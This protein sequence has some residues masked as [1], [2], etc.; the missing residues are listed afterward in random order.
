MKKVL[1]ILVTLTMFFA[2]CNDNKNIGNNSEKGDVNSEKASA[3]KN[4]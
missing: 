2:G 1:F 4:M 3:F